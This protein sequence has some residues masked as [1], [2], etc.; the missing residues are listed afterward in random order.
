ME[1]R[2]KKEEMKIEKKEQYGWQDFKK[3]VQILRSDEG[4]PWDRVQ[5][6]ESLRPYVLEEAAEVVAGVRIL[7]ET[8]DAENLCEELGD[9]L[10]QVFLHSEIAEEAQEFTLDEV[11]DGVAKKMIRRHPHVFGEKEKEQFYESW[12]KIKKREK[13]NKEW[14]KKPL[15]DIPMELGALTRAQ[16]VQKKAEN[17]YGKKTTFDKSIEIMEKSIAQIK[18]NTS[19]KNGEVDKNAIAQIFWENVNLA[20]ILQIHAEQALNDEIDTIIDEYE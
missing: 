11:V 5:T 7:R 12:E 6:H 16:K 8:G 19:E 3:I 2:M 10:L 18:Q 15:R 13:E 1:N 4:C 17:L 14:A 20:R 9:L